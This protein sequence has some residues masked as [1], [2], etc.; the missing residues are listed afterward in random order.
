MSM[1]K[2]VGIWYGFI[3]CIRLKVKFVVW[4]GWGV[5]FWFKIIIF[6]FWRVIVKVLNILV[7]LGCIVY[8]FVL[9]VRIVEILCRFFLILGILK[10]DFYFF[11]I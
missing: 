9:F 10:N 5:G 6:M 3:F 7:S 4:F 8:C 11:G 1:L 2:I